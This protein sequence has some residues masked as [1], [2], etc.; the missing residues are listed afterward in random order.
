MER[1][2]LLAADDYSVSYSEQGSY[3]YVTTN[4]FGCKH[5]VY[6]HLVVIPPTN[7]TLTL[8][9]ICADESNFEINYTY[10][11]RPIESYTVIFDDAAQEQ[12]F[13]NIYNQPLSKD[14]LTNLYFTV[15]I[16]QGETL[17]MPG[18]PY[19]ETWSGQPSYIKTPKKQYPRPDIYRM[20]VILHN[21]LCSYEQQTRDTLLNILYPSW[22]HE[23]HWNDG[24]V[25]FNEIYNGG[26]EFSRYQWYY[27]DK[28]IIGQTREYLYWLD[29]LNLNFGSEIDGE[30]CPSEYRVLLTRTDDGHSQFTCPICPIRIEDH[31][32]PKK[33]Y[34]AVVPTLVVASYPYVWILSSLRGEYYF[35]DVYGHPLSGRQRFVPDENNYVCQVEVPTVA[36]FCFITIRTDDG[37]MRTFKIVIV[38]AK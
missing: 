33:D 20:R 32:V 18:V 28:P 19:F 15:P 17:P 31:I 30:H 1:D 16:P 27:N 14:E 24:I 21:G 8:P 5:T 6:T 10:E 34:F 7:F 13:E 22:I 11:G 36:G 9:P 12:G 38:P 29:S 37:D 4:K 3:V 23:Q 2:S 25:L 26:Y 35:S